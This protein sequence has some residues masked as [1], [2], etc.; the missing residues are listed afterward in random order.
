MSMCSW[1]LAVAVVSSMV[2]ERQL[3]SAEKVVAFASAIIF[4]AVV[5]KIMWLR[6]REKDKTF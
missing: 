6:V 5:T 3:S 2:L 1:L 4:A